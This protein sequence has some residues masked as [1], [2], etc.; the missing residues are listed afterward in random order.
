MRYLTQ[1]GCWY[2]CQL[3]TVVLFSVSMSGPGTGPMSPTYRRVKIV[4]NFT[5]DATTAK[6]ST[7][8]IKTIKC[9]DTDV[10][11][12][13]GV[14][15]DVGPIRCDVTD[16]QPIKCDVTDVEPIKCDVTDVEPIKCIDTH[17]EPIK[18]IDTYVEPIK[19]DVT[20]VEPI[21]CIDTHVEPIKCIDTYV[22][23]IKCDVTDVQPIKCNI[24]DVERI[25]NI[26]PDVTS[27]PMT[28][29]SVVASPVDEANSEN[30]SIDAA[31]STSTSNLI[32]ELFKE[33]LAVKMET[34][35]AE[36]QAV[37]EAQKQQLLLK[38]ENTRAIDS[39]EAVKGECSNDVVAS[40]RRKRHHSKD[41]THKSKHRS[42][43]KSSKHKKDRSRHGS[44]AEENSSDKNSSFGWPME[45][46]DIV[47]KTGKEF[48]LT[49]SPKEE[50]RTDVDTNNARNGL[51]TVKS[52]A[53]DESV[54]NSST[55][56][57]QK[58]RLPANV[59]INKMNTKS[60]I[61]C[62]SQ[63][64]RETVVEGASDKHGIASD[65]NSVPIVRVFGVKGTK[66]DTDKPGED[67]Q[68]IV[69][70]KSKQATM[71]ASAKPEKDDPLW[72][73]AL[74]GKAT[75]SKSAEE[76]PQGVFDTTLVKGKQHVGFTF[77]LKITTESVDR[78]SR[79][80]R[81]EGE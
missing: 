56:Q 55:A 15:T 72:D 42:R 22:E 48:C 76:I 29:E 64:D 80:N 65:K 38:T 17:V 50:L 69:S 12:I 67:T 28:K 78:I 11:P 18:C 19:C 35:E 75:D 70:G 9:V 73:F 27:R 44:H 23:P 8:E 51:D 66:A 63:S 5:K 21:K 41:K 33:F 57:A 59:D 1:H 45:G 71:E 4:R 2:L 68:G 16:V 7:L 52:A 43:H 6:C 58:A 36:Y 62:A 20:D 81:E 31:Q 79:R 10:E 54:V 25:K 74:S 14:D 46:T 40:P 61:S 47:V 30:T 39:C 32:D 24:T 3:T 53:I 37:Q 26:L 60:P 77:G 49:N 13:K 34:I